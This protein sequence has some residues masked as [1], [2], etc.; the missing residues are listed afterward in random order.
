MP[1]Q[2]L[3]DLL[4]L[5]AVHEFYVG[6]IKNTL[7][8]SV[9]MPRDTNEGSKL[10]DRMQHSTLVL[11]RWL[12]VLDM[13]ITPHMVRDALEQSVRLETAEALLR[14]YVLKASHAE[15]DR[16]KADFVTTFLFRMT[17]AATGNNPGETAAK[18]EK[19]LQKV[20]VDMHLPP[21]PPEHCRVL[22]EFGA[23]RREVENSPHFDVL[24]GSGIAQ[25]ARQLKQALQASFYHPRA[26]ADVAAYN[27]YFGSR[28]DELRRQSA[29][30]TAGAATQGFQP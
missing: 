3:R 10:R 19:L 20:L 23:L 24:T 13:A 30:G 8:H 17:L 9:P 15:S 22:E 1:R 29:L 11:K 14:Y 27:A 2:Q 21:M 25:R 6:V 7:G 28:F 18:F 5:I 4:D 12:A 26:L 16:D